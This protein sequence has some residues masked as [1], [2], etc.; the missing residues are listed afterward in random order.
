MEK[1]RSHWY[2]HMLEEKH[3]KYHK[4]ILLKQTSNKQ[5][6]TN[7]ENIKMSKNKDLI[8]DFEIPPADY[9]TKKFILY[10]V[11]GNISAPIKNQ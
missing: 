4:P 10:L 6:L 7:S 3:I 5:K 8:I 9:L 11:E 2:Q 1:Y